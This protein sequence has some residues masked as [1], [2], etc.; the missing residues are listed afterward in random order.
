MHVDLDTRECL[1]ET[2]QI[3]GNVWLG[4]PNVAPFWMDPGNVSIG[5]QVEVSITSA[6]VRASVVGSEPV[7]T[8]KYWGIDCWVVQAEYENS[9]WWY[10]KATGLM[11]KYRG[12]AGGAGST[13]DLLDTNIQVGGTR[14]LFGLE[15]IV[16]YSLAGLVA[17]CAVGVVAILLARRRKAP[18]VPLP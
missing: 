5:T 1:G 4:T 18:P 2:K 10:D 13:A 7:T 12:Y 14:T 16:L 3:D 9:T 17:V 6:R 8:D 15:P 11:I